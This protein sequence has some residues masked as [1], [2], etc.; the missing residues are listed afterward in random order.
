MTE[1][2]LIE[3]FREAAIEVCG[4]VDGDITADAL[5]EDLG[6][7]SMDMIEIGMIVEERLDIVIKSEDF[8]GVTTVAGALAV[9]DRLVTAALVQ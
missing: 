2:E 8:E 9:F 1:Q 5:V 6:I 4:E 3:I 7:D